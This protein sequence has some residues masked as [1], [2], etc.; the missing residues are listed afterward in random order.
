[1]DKSS[2]QLLRSVSHLPY[3]GWVREQLNTVGCKVVKWKP[4]SRDDSYFAYFS[5][6]RVIL[7]VPECE[8]SFLVCLHEIGHVSSGDRSHTYLHEYNAE[9]W[10]ISRAKQYGI[11][12]K[13]YNAGA[14][15]YVRMHIY[16]NVVRDQL[17][18]AKIK[19]Y[20]LK[21]IGTSHAAIQRA[22]K[23]MSIT[24][25]RLIIS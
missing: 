2:R 14:K 15:R 23:S 19:P 11:E 25:K 20:V 8:Y 1:M 24:D 16:Q 5:E 6:R 13:R 17:D 3:L 4:W 10:C 21:W 7:P 12:S 9:R 18:I 22:T